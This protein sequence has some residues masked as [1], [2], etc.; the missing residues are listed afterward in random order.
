[1]QKIHEGQNI[2]SLILLY[3]AQ[4]E[5]NPVYWHGFYNCWTG[6]NRG[7][8]DKHTDGVIE[9]RIREGKVQT[10]LKPYAMRHSFITWQLAA[11]MT[12]ANVA[13]L[14]G[15][16]PEMIYKHYVS[17]EKDPELAFEF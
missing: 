5:G 16:S 6:Y 8:N 10:Y 7:K 17:A 2:L 3:F 12:P 4:S 14:V 11:G 15:N 9:E 1:L 13:K